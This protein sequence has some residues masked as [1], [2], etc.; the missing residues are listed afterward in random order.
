M[1]GA[2]CRA[3]PWCGFRTFS[4]GRSLIIPTTE[5]YSDLQYVRS[6]SSPPLRFLMSSRSE[7]P[8]RADAASSREGSASQD[9]RGSLRRGRLAPVLSPLSPLISLPLPQTRHM[10]ENYTWKSASG[11]TTHSF[12]R[13][14]KRI[15]ICVHSDLPGKLLALSY[16]PSS[17]S[18]HSR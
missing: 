6:P 4:F 11:Q 10:L 15:S 14:T 3:H 9:A 8:R 1:Q 2:G 13:D 16:L 17:S 12:P 18:R 5:W 7:R